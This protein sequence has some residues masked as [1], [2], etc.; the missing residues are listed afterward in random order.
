[1]QKSRRRTSGCSGTHPGED[2]PARRGEDG[3]TRRRTGTRGHAAARGSP[4]RVSAPRLGVVARLGTAGLGW[5][6]PP[7]LT[8][9]AP[10][11]VIAGREVSGGGGAP[12]PATRCGRQ[13]LKR[14]D[15]GKRGVDRRHRRTRCCIVPPHLAAS[16]D[17]A[18]RHGAARPL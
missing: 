3:R 8:S 12:L 16:F 11:R 18:R 6:L 14:G 17:S 9:L 2:N 13:R 15:R 4:R 1:M 5:G 10:A 7:V